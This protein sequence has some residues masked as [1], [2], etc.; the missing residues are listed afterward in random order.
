MET[1]MAIKVCQVNM[2]QR[3]RLLISVQE[4][5]AGKPYRGKPD[6][7]FD[8]G[9]VETGYDGDPAACDS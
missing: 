5:V 9:G 1:P 3:Q 4:K 8:E 7:R 2:S 6:V